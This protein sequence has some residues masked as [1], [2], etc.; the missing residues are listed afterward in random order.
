MTISLRQ[1]TQ[2]TTG[3]WIKL[4]GEQPHIVAAQKQALEQLPSLLI[5][6]LQY[7]IVDK[8]KAARQESSFTCGKAV[9]SVFDFVAKNE[10]APRPG[11]VLARP[12]VSADPRVLG[13][14]KPDHREQQQ[15]CV[16][17]LGAV[18]LH[19]AVK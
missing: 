15:V 17:P 2:H 4:F 14:K 16:E 1:I 9:A 8:P 13:R 18:G 11:A 10:L 6:A 5:A 3:Q 7:I 12:R 19:K